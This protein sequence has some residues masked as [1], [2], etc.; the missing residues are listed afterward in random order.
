MVVAGDRRATSGNVIARHDLE[1][2]V[3]VDDTTAAGYAGAVGPA[4]QML[5]LF[6]AEVEQYEKIEGTPISFP[7]KA[8]RLAAMLRDSLPMAMQGFEALPLL[9]GVDPDEP[10][11]ARAG[12]IV[13]FDVSGNIVPDSTG[14]ESIGSG[15]PYAK[16]A[17]KKRYSRDADRAGAVRAAVEALYDAAD[18]DSATGGPDLVRRI[19]PVVVTVTAAEGAVRVPP[20]EVEAVARQ[21]V[22]ARAATPGG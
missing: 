22:E 10:D 15:S 6:A 3:V 5:R 13:T 8:N 4:M 9:V 20:E 16:S 18:D 7:G 14:Y 12:R 19:F 11:P 17:L 2:V 21:V 1:K